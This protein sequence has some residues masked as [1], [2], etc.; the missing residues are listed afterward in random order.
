MTTQWLDIVRVKNNWRK[1]LKGWVAPGKTF[2]ETMQ[3]GYKASTFLK[4]IEIM[5]ALMCWLYGEKVSTILQISW[6]SIM[7]KIVE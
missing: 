1:N 6:V 7:A 3:E 2:R 5:N 4:H